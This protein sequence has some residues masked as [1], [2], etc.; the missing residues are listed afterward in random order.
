MPGV[1]HST[2]SGLF[3]D[4]MNSQGRARFGARRKWGLPAKALPGNS[5]AIR[6]VLLPAS[7][8]TAMPGVRLSI[9]MR[10]FVSSGQRRRSWLPV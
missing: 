5:C 2:R 6:L 4:L 7:R 3:P 10:A 9:T 1:V 8:V